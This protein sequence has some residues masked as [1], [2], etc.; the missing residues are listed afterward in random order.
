MF[1]IFWLND[2]YLVWDVAKVI[3]IREDLLLF[4]SLGL[5]VKV[6]VDHLISDRNWDYYEA[7]IYSFRLVVYKFLLI[8]KVTLLGFHLNTGGVYRSLSFLEESELQFL[9]FPVWL[10]KAFLSFL[11]PSQLPSFWFLFLLLSDNLGFVN[12]L[13]VSNCVE[14]WVYF[15]VI[16]FSLW[17]GDFKSFCLCGTGLQFLFF[18]SLW[19]CWKVLYHSWLFGLSSL[20]FELANVRRKK[21][22]KIGR[23]TLAYLIISVLSMI[24]AP[25]ILPAFIFCFPALIIVSSRRIGLIRAIIVLY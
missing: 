21:K 25:P 8:P 3:S 12:C 7:E 5:T 13:K 10:S 17:V 4:L 23:K 14:S 9:T 20:F 19:D 16:S 2:G 15:I 11:S 22:W 24:L 18:S 6:R 1:G